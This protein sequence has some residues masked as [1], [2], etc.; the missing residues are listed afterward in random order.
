MLA[1][2]DVDKAKLHTIAQCDTL[3]FIKYNQT[4]V[5]LKVDYLA[6]THPRHKEINVWYLAATNY[7][8]GCGGATGYDVVSVAPANVPTNETGARI[9]KV[10][11]GPLVKKPGR[12]RWPHTCEGCKAA[13]NN[14]GGGLTREVEPIRVEPSKNLA[15][16]QGLKGKCALCACGKEMECVCGKDCG[17]PT[18]KVGA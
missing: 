1:L 12:G 8:V 10:C 7:V 5:E 13:G 6:P 15:S 2:T 9:C 4:C 18:H 11:S 17:H 16:V 14:N 3:A